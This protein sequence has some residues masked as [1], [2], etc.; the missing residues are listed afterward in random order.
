MKLLNTISDTLFIQGI[1]NHSCLP[2]WMDFGSAE[3]HCGFC[4]EQ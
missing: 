1:P 2:F 3:S 4:A